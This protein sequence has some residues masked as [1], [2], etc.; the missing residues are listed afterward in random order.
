MKK[1]LF[2]AIFIPIVI[3]MFFFFRPGGHTIWSVIVAPATQKNFG[4]Y[5]PVIIKTI[6]IILYFTLAGYISVILT[7]IS[8]KISTGK[9]SGPM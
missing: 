7:A 2:F 4:T 3:I 8:Y 1:R 6:I 9:N 5:N